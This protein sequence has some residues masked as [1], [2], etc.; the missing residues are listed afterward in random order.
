MSC[1]YRTIAGETCD[2][3]VM[4]CVVRQGCVHGVDPSKTAP[5]FWGVYERTTT[6]PDF[7]ARHMEDF[8]TLQQAGDFADRMAKTNKMMALIV[9]RIT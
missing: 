9:P 3:E 6:G 4:A 5:E 7:R 8:N 2:Y 1:I